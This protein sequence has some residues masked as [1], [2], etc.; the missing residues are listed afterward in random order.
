MN[1]VP[2]II[3]EDG[4]TGLILRY[5]KINETVKTIRNEHD[6]A[7]FL[8]DAHVTF[9]IPFIHINEMVDTDFQKL[10]NIVASYPQFISRFNHFGRF[11]G[12]LF[13]QP[14]E[15]KMLQTLFVDIQTSFP[16]VT[17]YGNKNFK[18]QPHL[19]LAMGDEQI[20]DT[21][22]EKNNYLLGVEEKIASLDLM[23]M[24]H[25][26]WFLLQQFLFQN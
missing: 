23:V 12:V 1:K 15:T 11:P 4:R 26:K 21:I 19:T 20:L 10:T 18:Y 22:E 6:P 25:E 14:D 2:Q 8:M 13:L 16:H 3:F 24:K 9:F 17:S 5:P 7:S